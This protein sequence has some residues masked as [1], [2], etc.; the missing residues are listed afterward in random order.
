M[1]LSVGDLIV[2]VHKKQ[3][4]NLHISVLPPNGMVRISAPKEYNDDLICAAVVQRM[5]WIRKQQAVFSQQLRQSKREMITRES[6]FLWGKRYLLEIKIGK[7]QHHIERQGTN[8]L[9]LYI[10]NHLT[11]EKKIEILNSY[12]KESLRKVMI[13]IV[14][15]W[16]NQLNVKANF[17]GV[18]RM[19]TKWGSCNPAT[20]RI[21]LNIE[22]VKKPIKCLEYVIVHELIHLLESHHNKRFIDLMDYYM[23][24]WRSHKQ[25]LKDTCILN[26]YDN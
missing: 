9:V 19:K 24:K 7:Y 10:S 16:Q 6:H 22:L 8:R 4:H 13:P 11:M 14:N 21:W 3:I 25:T 26:Y 2:T 15:K 18:R 12:Y 5:S 1:L 23:P 20:A 17:I